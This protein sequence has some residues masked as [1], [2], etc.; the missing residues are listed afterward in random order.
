MGISTLPM[1]LL[2]SAPDITHSSLRSSTSKAKSCRT[3]MIS[4][5][6]DCHLTLICP[7]IDSDCTPVSIIPKDTD[8]VSSVDACW[9]TGELQ[10]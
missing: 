3:C 7:R 1:Y 4:A 6:G 10:K 8:V 9:V 5:S 2:K